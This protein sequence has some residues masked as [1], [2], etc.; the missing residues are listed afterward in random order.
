MEPMFYASLREAGLAALVEIVGFELMLS[1]LA[2]ELAQLLRQP[3]GLSEQALEWFTHHSEVDL[4]HAEQ[5][6]DAVAEYASYYE[7]ELREAT[8]IVDTATSI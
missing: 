1:R 4:E 3:R 5:G 6:L 8:D 7:L 2:S